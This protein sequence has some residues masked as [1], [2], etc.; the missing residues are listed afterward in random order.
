MDLDVL[1]I[2][3]QYERIIDPRIPMVAGGTDFSF[4]ISTCNDKKKKEGGRGAGATLV[5]QE[6]K[7]CADYYQDTADASTEEQ[8]DDTQN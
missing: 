8:E 1:S 6:Q 5:S 7:D 3:Y 2:E 4:I